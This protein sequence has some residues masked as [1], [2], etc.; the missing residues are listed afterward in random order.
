[1]FIAKNIFLILILSG[2]YYMSNNIY[3]RGGYSYG[4]DRY[5]NPR[6]FNNFNRDDRLRNKKVGEGSSP[7]YIRYNRDILMV[8]IQGDKV[9]RRDQNYSN[10]GVEVRAN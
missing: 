10:C 6:N 7:V 4:E 2:D 5:N 3:N 1:M 8:P 9:D